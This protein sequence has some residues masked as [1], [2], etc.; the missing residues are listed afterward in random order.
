MICSCYT[1]FISSDFAACVMHTVRFVGNGAD[2]RG[3][4]VAAAAVHSSVTAVTVTAIDGVSISGAHV[5]D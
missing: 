2:Q 3:R 5:S 1:A 4:I